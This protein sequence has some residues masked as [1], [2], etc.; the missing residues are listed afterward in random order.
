VRS[1]LEGRDVLAILPTGAGKSVCFQVPAMVQGGLTLVV[2]PLISLMQDQ[3][4]ALHARGI[5]AELLNSGQGRAA[6]EA[7]LAAVGAG[8][9]RLL[10]V[11]PER[12]GTLAP[13]LRALGVR[14]VRL[15][16]DE[17]H[18]VDEWGDDFRPAYRSLARLR[19]E[20]GNPPVLALTGSAT[21]ETRQQILLRLAI[22]HPAVHLGSFDRP[23]LWLGVACVADQRHRIRA[24]LEILGAEDRIVLVYAPTRNITEGLVRVLRQHGYGVEAYHAGLRREER[25]TTLQRFLADEIEVVVATSAFGMGIDKPNVRLVVHWMMPSSPEAYYQEAGRAGRDGQFARCV[26]L[27]HRDDCRWHRRQLET[28]FP[29]RRLVERLWRNPE[30]RVRAPRHVLAATDR[31]AAE[32]RPERGRVDWGPVRARRRRADR[33]ITAMERYAHGK[34]CRRAELVGYFGERLG[35]CSGCD[36]CGNRARPRSLGWEVQARLD[37]LRR[38][39]GTRSAPWGGLVLEPDTLIRLVRLAPQSAAEL[40]A[41]DGV[42]P[43]V[44]ERMGALILGALGITAKT[45]VQA[46][47][48]APSERLLRVWRAE[49]GK[50]LG[51]P[52]FTVL[53][54]AVL[55]EIIRIRPEN[56]GELAQIP[57]VGPRFLAKFGDQ[58]LSLM[59]PVPRPEG[60]SSC[61][62]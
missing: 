7:S 29:P 30:Q 6:R 25:A 58:V 9:V 51:V 13:G 42:G 24:L 20:L 15:V 39:L 26:L 27:H 21:V 52:D 53:G 59:A 14:P 34:S 56:R 17:A 49:T 35:R 31:L 22:T 55:A 41:I 32:L 44:A 11:S 8:S 4:Q 57:G 54:D 19:H 46:S 28:T 36:R 50:R 40:A 33:R 38:A 10:Y 16:V 48:C 61:P 18:C 23:N 12:L 37:R 47:D 60:G 2:S 62:S 5:P 43:V 3:V 1:V 45:G